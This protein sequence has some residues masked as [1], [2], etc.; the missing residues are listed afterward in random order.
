MLA[1]PAQAVSPTPA[2]AAEAA[3]A[4]KVLVFHGAAG[5]AGRPGRQGHRRHP[6]SWA[7]Q[8]GFTVDDSADPAVFTFGNLARYRAVVFLSA[9]GVTLDDAQ[10]A[11]FQAYVKAGGGF[12]GVHDAARAQPES[13]WFTGLIG[14]RPAAGLP[15]AEKPVSAT[16]SADNPPNETAAKAIDGR[17]GT[18]WLTFSPTGWL[19]AKLAK[20]VVVDRYAL[21]SANDF[22]GRDPKDWT[23][24]GSQD[25]T[26]WTDLDTRTGET[27]PQRFQTK[28][29]SFT[30]STAYQHYRLTSPRTAVS[31]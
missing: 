22:P 28:Q 9:N 13:S 12:V 6:S 23:L 7:R 2:A 1:L 27:F 24:Q 17:R 25:G 3:A 8:Q 16:A 21:T 19:A 20:P 14:S 5:R 31:R 30:N 26:T 11:A 29:Y 10:E 18:K 4:V 15:N